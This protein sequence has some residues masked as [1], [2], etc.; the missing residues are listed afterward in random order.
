MNGFV[1]L[2]ASDMHT[3][4]YWANTSINK[5]LNNA[6]F[7]D[8]VTDARRAAGTLQNQYPEYEVKV[9]SVTNAIQITPLIS[10]VATSYQSTD[11]SI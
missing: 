8:S 6:S 3:V 2:F 9:V 7:F 5:D 1:I 4:G 10:N 11:T